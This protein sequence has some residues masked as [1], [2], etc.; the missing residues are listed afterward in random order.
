MF[1]FGVGECDNSD[2]KEKQADFHLGDSRAAVT[3]E[4]AGFGRQNSSRFD[5][6][7]CSLSHVGQDVSQDASEPQA[8]ANG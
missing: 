1:V 7:V 4:T 2:D 8:L 6:I 5:C 3:E